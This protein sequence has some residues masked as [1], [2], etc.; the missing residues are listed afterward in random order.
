[1][2]PPA[3]LS[4][5]DYFDWRLLEG[6]TPV[7]DQGSCGSCWA[8]GATGAFESAYYIAEG[9]IP[10]FSEQVL[11]SCDENS[12]GCDGGWTGSAYNFFSIYGA[13]DESCMPYHAT[14]TEPC[15]MDTCD[16][17]CYLQGY[18]LVPNN[19]SAIKNMLMIGPVSTSFTV[20]DDFY[21]YQG[22]CYEHAD[23]DPTNHAV[24]IVGWDDNECNGEGAWIV[25]NSWGAGWGGPN[26]MGYFKIKYASAAIGSGTMLPV[27]QYAG[28]AEL[29]YSPDSI[30]VE[31]DPGTPQTRTIELLNIGDGLLRYYIDGYT[32]TDQD[33]CG[34]YWRDSDDDDGPT[35]N[36]VD[37]TGYGQQVD[38]WGYNNDGNSGQLNL[39]FNF[40]FYG[41]T[42]NQFN[43]CTNGWISFNNAFIL[44]WENRI[45]PHWDQPNNMVAVFFDNLNMEL[46][47]Q[48]YYYTNNTDSAIVTWDH[49]PDSDQQGVFTFQV[50][51]VAPD[52]IICQYNTMG[53]G[54][55]DECS[56]GI[57]NR[58]ATVGTQVVCNNPYV[59]DQ[60]AVE[61]ILG[62]APPPLTWMNPSPQSGTIPGFGSQQLDVTLDPAGLSSGTYRAMMT[63]MSNSIDNPVA[64]I[65]V[66][67]VLSAVGIEDEPASIP[68]DFILHPVYP[69]PFNPEATISYNIPQPGDVALEIY[70]ILGQRVET[71]YDGYQ[72][73]G[74]HTLIWKA[75]DN[76]SGL[77]L[78]K[79]AYGDQVRFAK[80]NLLK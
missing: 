33:S 29:D 60:M 68:A 66:T 26:C 55:L 73:A 61:F 48:I 2:P 80:M 77:Y 62:E 42:Y 47:G 44:E 50:I 19:V 70:N 11:V 53:P 28:V 72:E 64:N 51:L 30:W 76:S 8:F 75:G 46:G 23:T 25:K 45:I 39:G 15:A 49:I 35:Y 34:Y 16:P 78:V 9:V 59:H 4:T 58:Y 57:E 12:N 20:Y 6:V 74:E 14:D 54:R 69:N 36:W 32:I 10:D 24:V 22:G 56:I 31:T 40:D 67:L 13:Y 41:N 63:I 38:F 17:V 27:Y 71:L 79:L 18:Q 21:S 37:I 3:L 7:K 43:I 65:P 52:R 1:L 5:A